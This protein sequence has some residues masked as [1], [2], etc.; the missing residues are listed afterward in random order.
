MQQLKEFLS[1]MVFTANYIHGLDGSCSLILSLGESEADLKSTIEVLNIGTY[2]RL[3]VANLSVFSCSY[4]LF[5]LSLGVWITACPNK[6]R[7]LIGGKA[8][9]LRLYLSTKRSLNYHSVL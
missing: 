9:S 4:R 5:N 3:Y 6:T 2:L 7:I 8:N 1:G